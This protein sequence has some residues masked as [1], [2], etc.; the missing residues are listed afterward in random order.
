MLGDSNYGI[1]SDDAQPR[2]FNI[3][4][5]LKHPKFKLPS[6]YNDIALIKVNDPVEFSNYIRPACL[7]STQ[8]IDSRH[9]I[10]SGWGRVNYSSATS[11][12][13][14]KVVL[15]LFTHRECNQSYLNEIGRQLNRGIVDVTQICAGSHNSEKDTCQVSASKLKT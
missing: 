14:Q 2:Q 1:K 10:A 4:E 9:V 12:Q 3:V 8:W 5:R 11:E 15:E 6:K 13:L 7:P